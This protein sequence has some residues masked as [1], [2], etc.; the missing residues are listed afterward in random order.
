ML[1][2]TFVLLSLIALGW[3]ERKTLR[4][5]L[6]I[7]QPA[8]AGRMI[9]AVGV[10]LGLLVGLHYFISEHRFE[11][12]NAAKV[13]HHQSGVQQHVAMALKKVR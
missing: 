1:M 5:N 12:N 2:L 9:A 3:M 13:I 4:A 10:A 6:L 8:Q 11:R 7:V